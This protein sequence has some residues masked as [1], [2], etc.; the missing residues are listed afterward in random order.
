MEDTLNIGGNEKTKQ[1]DTL[2]EILY[3]IK[4]DPMRGPGFGNPIM[5]FGFRWNPPHIVTY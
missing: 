2:G 4:M 5:Q 3:T 1:K